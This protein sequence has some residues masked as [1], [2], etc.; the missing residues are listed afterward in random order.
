MLLAAAAA[1]AH[2]VL[3]LDQSQQ[4]LEDHLWLACAAVGLLLLPH[5]QQWRLEAAGLWH[6]QRHLRAFLR[7]AQGW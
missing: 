3:H 5:H 1:S 2:P 4:L 6:L 7:L